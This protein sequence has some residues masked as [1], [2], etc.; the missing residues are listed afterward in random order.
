M[1]MRDVQGTILKKDPIRIV[2]G[3]GRA[4]GMWMDMTAWNMLFDEDS[5]GLLS[6]NTLQLII[7]RAMNRAGD[8]AWT[9]VIRHIGRNYNIKKKDI[10]KFIGKRKAS[11][12]NF[13]YAIRA[14]KSR[15]GREDHKITFHY[16]GAKQAFS[17]KGRGQGGRVRAGVKVAL[18]KSGGKKIFQV[19]EKGFMITKGKNQ[20]AYIRYGQGRKEIRPMT[21]PS[22][23]S[24]LEDGQVRAVALRK[25]YRAFP[26][27]LEH[28]IDREL[29]KEFLKVTR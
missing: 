22:I 5:R 3:P 13:S 1:V 27:R 11:F 26:K 25:F 10:R 20:I 28:E 8:M 6:E 14:S 21:G 19:F 7:V 15:S 2:P 18:R 24:I 16:F 12:N 23:G 29:S 17:G 4:D 9:Q